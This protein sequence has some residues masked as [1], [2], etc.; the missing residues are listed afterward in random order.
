MLKS[1]LNGG[2]LF[3]R[4]STCTFLE[5]RLRLGNALTFIFL[6][7]IQPFQGYAQ[8]FHT[9]SNRALKVYNEG[10]TSFDYLDFQKAE[11]SFKEA[12]NLDPKFY[13][14]YMM[15]GELYLKQ[16]RY[17]ESADNYRMAV[18]IDSLFFKP[19]F[20]SLANAEMMTGN[21]KDA[22]IHFRLYLEQKGMSEKNKLIAGKNLKNCEFAI[23]AIKKPVDFSPVNAGDGINTGED[24]YWPSITADGQTLMFTRQTLSYN[25]SLFLGTRHSRICI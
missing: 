6:L 3:N 21:Y 23:E 1:I 13:E 4:I 15:L 19:V 17:Q 5:H 11:S 16:K 2:S 12:L 25:N 9:I 10:V 7:S 22:L 14:A 8:G 24:E 20:F 18:R